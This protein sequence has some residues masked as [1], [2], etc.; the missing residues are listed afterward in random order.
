[1]FSTTTN[2]EELTSAFYRDVD[3]GADD[4]FDRMLASTAS[5]AFNDFPPVS[6]PAGIAEMVKGWKSGFRSVEHRLDNILVDGDK[7]TT[8]SEVTVV[9]T[10]HDGTRLETKGCSISEYANDGLMVSWRVYVDTS[11]SSPAA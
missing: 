11:K 10:F 9:Y 7:R 1:M 3:A 5:F 4:V 2:F 8:V 6:T